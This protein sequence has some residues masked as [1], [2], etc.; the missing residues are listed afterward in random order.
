M[1]ARL[2]LLKDTLST[3][4]SILRFHLRPARFLLVNPEIGR[5]SY[6][7]L[8]FPTAARRSRPPFH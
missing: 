6:R 1:A 2:L 5:Q 7:R 4:F 3:G 8:A